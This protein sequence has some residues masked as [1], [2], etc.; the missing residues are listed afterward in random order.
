MLSPILELNSND[1]RLMVRK[2]KDIEG[3]LSKLFRKEIRAIAKPVNEEIKKL[4]PNEPPLSGM[5]Q[6]VKWTNKRTGT[7]G[8]SINE[9][10]L[11]WKGTGQFALAD[12]KGK[13]LSPKSTTISQAMKRG[14]N[15]LTTSLVKII[16]NSPA[17]SMADMAGKASRG[18]FSG[19]SRMYSYRKRN[20][21]I[22]RRRHRL[23]GQGAKMIQEL[24][25]RYGSPSRFAW[26]A[27]EGKL[28]AVEREIDKVITKYYIIAN[29]G[30]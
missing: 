13:A 16:V 5:G 1:V 8:Y 17:V 19:V 20:G 18:N 24:Q 11:N 10:R 6:V 27:L 30:N 9:G 12:R 14:K 25:A 23:A 28:D 2:L 21:E 29:K 26:K 22:V 15:T 4:I 3:D 7:S